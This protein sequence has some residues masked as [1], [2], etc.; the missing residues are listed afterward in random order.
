MLTFAPD[1][2]ATTRTCDV[3]VS[4]KIELCEG[5]A[6]GGRE[7]EREKVSPFFQS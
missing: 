7:K 5:E 2:Q 6:E 3:R 4:C 1:M